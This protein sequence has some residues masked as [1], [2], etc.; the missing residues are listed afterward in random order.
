MFIVFQGLAW[1]SDDDELAFDRMIDY[2]FNES[3]SFGQEFTHGIDGTKSTIFEFA[4]TNTGVVDISV[5]DPENQ[6]IYLVDLS[7]SDVGIGLYLNQKYINFSFSPSRTLY[8]V[9]DPESI[10][11]EFFNTETY[12]IEFDHGMGSEITTNMDSIYFGYVKY[13]DDS[14]SPDYYADD[15]YDTDMLVS[16]GEN[17]YIYELEDVDENDNFLPD[18]QDDSMIGGKAGTAVDDA[19]EGDGFNYYERDNADANLY[20]AI[21]D[22]GDALIDAYLEHAGIDESNITMAHNAVIPEPRFYALFLGILSFGL[23][24]Y[25]RIKNN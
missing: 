18:F 13:F 6:M 5:D 7:T 23:V 17:T 3:N 15:H 10:D 11:P 1:S 24:V 16:W 8:N 21:N 12:R 19:D 2:D 22:D 14:D 25:R 4:F 9:E 20:A